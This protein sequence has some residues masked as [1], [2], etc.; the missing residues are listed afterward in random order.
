MKIITEETII[1]TSPE[2]IWNFLTS[3]HTDDN[4]K[5]WHPADHVVYILRKGDMTKVG[6][7]AYFVEH[8]G[9]FTLK[10]TYTTKV[11]NYPTYL[12]YRAVPPLSWLHAGRGSFQM[13]PVDPKTTRFIA[14][15]EYGYNMPIIGTIID[16]VIEKFIRYEDARKHMHEEGENLKAIL[17]KS[18]EK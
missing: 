8:M 9:N 11:A 17:E 10:L 13:L 15:V 14:Y 5:K 1:K 18:H 4:Y 16:L 3:L 6:G 12:E 7:A 2:N